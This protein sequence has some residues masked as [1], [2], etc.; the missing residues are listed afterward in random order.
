[1]A[2][3]LLGKNFVPPDVHGKV[4]GKARYAAT[5]RSRS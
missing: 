1:M 3:D 5:P 4:T 2:Y